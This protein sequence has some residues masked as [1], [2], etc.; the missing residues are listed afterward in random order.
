[1]VHKV[2]IQVWPENF[3]LIINSDSEVEGILTTA[4]LELFHAAW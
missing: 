3:V 4:L 2:K 1:M